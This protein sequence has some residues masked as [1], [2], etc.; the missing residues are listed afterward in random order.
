MGDGD[1]MIS[2]ATTSVSAPAFQ[3]HLDG[4]G[5]EG[6]FFDLKGR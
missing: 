5:G 1:G 6:T 3:Q 2:A 4:A